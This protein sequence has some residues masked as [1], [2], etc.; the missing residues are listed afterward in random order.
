M[1]EMYE[2][3][4]KIGKGSF[5]VVNLCKGGDGDF[6]VKKIDLS[7]MSEDEKKGALTEVDLLSTLGSHQYIVHYI[8]S[9]IKENTLHIVMEYCKGGDLSAKILHRRKERK[10]FEEDQI[11][12]WFVQIAL[13]LDEMHNHRNPILHR[14]LKPQNIFLTAA[15]DAKIGDFG[16]SK[17]LLSDKEMA[18]TAIGTPYYFSPE[19]CESKPY[20][21][22]SDIWALGCI[23]YELT[24][25]KRA[26]T[27]KKRSALEEKIIKGRYPPISD[28]Y[29]KDL[30]SLIECMLKQDPAHRYPIEKILSLGC[31]EKAIKA[32]IGD[33]DSLETLEN[34]RPPVPKITEQKDSV[35]PKSTMRRELKLRSEKEP[36]ISDG[37]VLCAQGSV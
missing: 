18:S 19:I 32:I 34:E 3:V 37:R 22:S 7:E 35:K 5:G 16:I 26:F 6:V 8:E 15:G 33:V 36:D 11:M 2:F 28:R 1:A 17:V 23:L 20:T 31:C 29:S 25:L 30:S 24:T 9:F 27:A 4:R 10:F 12:K 14:D 13:G 21:T